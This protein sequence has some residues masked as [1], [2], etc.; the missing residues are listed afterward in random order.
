MGAFRDAQ[1]LSAIDADASGFQ[2]GIEDERARV[3]GFLGV[4]VEAVEA[5]NLI[6][7]DKRLEGL[8]AIVAGA[9]LKIEELTQDNG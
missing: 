8:K 6:D 4:S 9:Q 5:I 3:A 7:K 1:M 2:D